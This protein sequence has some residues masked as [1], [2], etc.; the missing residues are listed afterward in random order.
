VQEITEQIRKWMNTF[1]NDYTDRNAFTLEEMDRLYKGNYGITRTE[2]NKIFV[3]DLDRSIKI[4][5][6]GSNIGNQLLLLQQ[7]GFKNLFGIEINSYAVE[8][9][10]AINKNINLIQGSAF[11]IPFKNDF[12]DLVFTSGVLIHIAPSDI[13]KAITE[14]CRCSDKYIWGFEYYADKYTK[15]EYREHKNMLWKTNFAKLYLDSFDDLELI[16]EQRLKYLNNENV[17][18]MFLIKKIKKKK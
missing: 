12:F 2:L 14:I 5:E 10:K 15:V 13:H 11:D 7:M 17:D 16:K 18:T 4:L 8:R 1:G 3:E 6:V 9:A